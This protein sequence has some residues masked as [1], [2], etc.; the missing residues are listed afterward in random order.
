[1]IGL[2]A[3]PVDKVLESGWT[4]AKTEWHELAVI[5]ACV[6][7][8]LV[9]N[10]LLL[11]V[12]QV[13]GTVEVQLDERQGVAS[14]SGCGSRTELYWRVQVLAM[15]GLYNKFFHSSSLSSREERRQT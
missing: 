6:V 9:F 2:S 3:C 14:G 12:L 7:I 5:V 11:D 13:V 10:L 8:K 1:M 15:E 4:I